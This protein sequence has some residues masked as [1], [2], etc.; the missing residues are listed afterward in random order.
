MIAA[1]LD[2]TDRKRIELELERYR[3]GLEELVA[4]RTAELNDTVA[5]LQ[6]EAAARER[7][8]EDLRRSDAATACCSSSRPLR[9]GS[10]ISPASGRRWKR[11]PQKA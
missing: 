1:S 7:T 8:Q 5:K 9:S 10:M 4:M 2:I 11:F 3:R 6:Q